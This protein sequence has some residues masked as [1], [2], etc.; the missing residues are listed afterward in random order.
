MLPLAGSIAYFVLEVMPDL[1]GTRRG[2]KTVQKVQELVNPDR[3]LKNAAYEYSLAKTT[4]NAMRLAEE[5]LSKEQ[6]AEAGLLYRDC[7]KGVHQ[8]D[9]LFMYGLARAEFGL[10]NFGTVK[11]ILDDLIAK[12]PDYKNPDA[13]LLYARVV[14]ALG[15]TISAL[16]EYEVLNGYYLGPEASYH[17]AKLLQKLGD[18][19]KALAVYEKI[20]SKAKSSG[21]HYNDIHSKW[22]KLTSLELRR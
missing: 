11:S 21:T 7:L 4:E 15:D 10:Q 12:N 8:Y 19:E 16:H 14:E 13:H 17:Y 22:I 6:Y 5:L 2:R 1:A 3:E 9:P 20:L 18:T